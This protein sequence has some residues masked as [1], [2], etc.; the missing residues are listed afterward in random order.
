MEMEE[1][2]FQSLGQEDSLENKMVTHSSPFAWRIPWT[3]RLGR[4]Q[5]MGSQRVRHD[6]ATNTTTKYFIRL[7]QMRILNL[8]KISS[9]NTILEVV[10]G[11]RERISFMHMEDSKRAVDNLPASFCFSSKSFNLY[12][13]LRKK[14]KLFYHNHLLFLSQDNDGLATCHLKKK[15]TNIRDFPVGPVAK[16]PCS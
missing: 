16:T 4:L 12:S 1:I 2:W 9:F 15:I 5:A 14:K 13:I 3:E 6:W 11:K 8:V 7:S 10:E